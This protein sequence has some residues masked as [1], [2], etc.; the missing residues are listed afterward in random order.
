MAEDLPPKLATDPTT[1]PEGPYR[2]HFFRLP[3]DEC[4]IYALV[5]MERASGCA[6]DVGSS[7]LRIVS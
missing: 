3:D 1:T 6:E 7:H 4:P 5:R 2:P